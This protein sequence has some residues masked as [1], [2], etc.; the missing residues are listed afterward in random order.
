MEWYDSKKI[1]HMSDSVILTYFQ[2]K[3]ESA[4]DNIMV[5]RFNFE[6]NIKHQTKYRYSEII[7]ISR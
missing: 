1:K 5:Y 6:R 3:I 4:E 7:E 2:Y